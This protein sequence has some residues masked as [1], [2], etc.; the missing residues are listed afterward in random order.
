M[1]SPQSLPKY[2]FSIPKVV[3][4]CKYI[5]GNVHHI[6]PAGVYLDNEVL[7]FD[8]LIV[9][10]G[11]TYSIPFEVSKV[12]Q[13]FDHEND[14]EEDKKSASIISPYSSKSILN[15]Y[16][17]LTHSKKI[18][19]V[20]GKIILNFDNFKGGPVGIECAGELCVNLPDSKIILMTSDNVLLS[21]RTKKIQQ[22]A[23]KILSSYKNC[24]IHFNRYVSKVVGNRVY[25]RYKTEDK[26]LDEKF[27]ETEAV[28]V[29]VG[30]RPNSMLFRSHMLD[31]ISSRGYVHV[32]D[33]FQVKYNQHSFTKNQLAEQEK[34]LLEND[35]N[36]LFSQMEAF[37]VL[38]GELEEDSEDLGN[39]IDV[40]ELYKKRFSGMDSVTSPK[41]SRPS[42][43]D[44]N[45][46]SNI[47]AIG[48]VI[49][50][51][52]EKLAFYAH[53]HGESVASNIKIL[54]NS[55]DL[56]DY[57]KKVKPYVSDSK[58]VS[59]I[60]IGNQGMLIKGDSILQKGKLAVVAKNSYEK[61]FIT[62]FLP[63]SEK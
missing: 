50:T 18:V 60:S 21:R 45:S 26:S 62:N 48:D 53:I 23:Y 46:Y 7:H 39:E 14:N 58:F 4:K 32:N 61:Y 37:N 30:F 63:S 29:C 11:C 2:E 38:D 27:I 33:Y 36:E 8:Y 44:L 57:H 10:T 25:Y 15:S 12:E 35:M 13:H 24:E 34:K 19:V 1:A 3:D 16:Y 20:G 6:S 54:E 28:I 5:Q 56:D 51:N 47:Y 49:E 22:S 43:F 42:S 59:S 17:N 9:A 55:I 52:E 31:S 41:N 40:N